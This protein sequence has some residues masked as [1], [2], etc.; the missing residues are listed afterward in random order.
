MK[1][2]INEHQN[3]S[4]KPEEDYSLFDINNRVLTISDIAKDILDRC[5]GKVRY[6]RNHRGYKYKIPS[7]TGRGSIQMSKPMIKSFM[8][9]MLWRSHNMIK[10][11]RLQLM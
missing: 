3:S 10:L 11:L 9:R 2:M 7:A 8:K 1:V 4:A 5:D 6:S